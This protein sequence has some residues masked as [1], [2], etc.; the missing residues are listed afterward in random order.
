MTAPFRRVAD[1]CSTLVLSSADAQRDLSAFAPAAAA[2]SRIL[3]FVA[4]PAA[5]E[6]PKGKDFLAQTYDIRQPYFFLPNQF[7]RHKNHRLVVD[8]LGLLA[9]RGRAPLVVSTGHPRDYR[10]PDHFDAL[11]AHAEAV[12]AAPYFRV[13]GLVPYDHLSTLLNHA[14]AAINPSLFEGWSTTVEEAK[15]MGKTVILSDIPVHREQAPPGGVFVA[16]DDPA[17]MAEALQA[18][19]GAWS[20]VAD[21]LRQAEAA[22]RLPG[23][24]G[25]LRPRL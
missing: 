2:K 15:S 21:G 4:S 25:G 24:D 7:W 11:M 19:A 5:G 20:E 23:A 6:A 17:A 1:W 14:I 22:S 9:K 10:S 12:G 3:H 8:A 13:L 16:P 18:T